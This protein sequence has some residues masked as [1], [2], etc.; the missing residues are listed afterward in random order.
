MYRLRYDDML[1]KTNQYFDSAHNE[2]LQYLFTHGIIGLISYIVL[3]VA[4]ISR[5][6]RSGINMVK[7]NKKSSVLLGLSFSVFSY[8]IQAIVNINIPIAA[9][10]FFM[11]IMLTYALSKE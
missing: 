1:S 4:V 7:D 2:Y 3:L 10:F 8:A 11:F 6:F 9:V 5:G